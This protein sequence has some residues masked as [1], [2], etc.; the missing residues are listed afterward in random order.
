L[1]LGFTHEKARGKIGNTP[2]ISIYSVLVMATKNDLTGWLVEALKANNGRA[3]IV[4]ICKHVWKN[5]EEELRR[6][7]DLF[8]TWQ[9]DIRWAATH[10]RKG[11]ILRPAGVSPSGVWE[12]A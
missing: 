3:S 10:L 9:Y 6:S 4:D 1:R 11:G 12:L 5:H 7:G 2:D 8:F